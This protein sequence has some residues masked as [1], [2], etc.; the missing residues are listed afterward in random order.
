M[1]GHLPFGGQTETPEANQKFWPL[2]R[3]KDPT[4]PLRRAGRHFTTQRR[5][6]TRCNLEW[7]G[8]FSDLV[9]CY[10]PNVSLTSQLKVRIVTLARS[11][12]RASVRPRVPWAANT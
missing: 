10:R 6:R 11:S 8:P 1:R 3:G 4:H 2:P 5:G 7:L 9:R 12:A